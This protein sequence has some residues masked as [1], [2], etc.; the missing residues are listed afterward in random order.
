M[1]LLDVITNGNP[2]LRLRATEVEDVLDPSVQKLITDMIPTMYE[3]DGIGL[4]ANQV[5]SPVRVAVIVPDPTQYRKL[6]GKQDQKNVIVAIN[7]IIISHSVST[8]KGEEGCLSVP[9]IYG[10]V[11]RWKTVTV[12]FQD[13]EGKKVT[14]KASGLLARVFQHE[15]DHLDGILFIDKAENLYELEAPKITI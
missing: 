8:E 1:K 15:I 2:T 7:P 12:S 11:K 5:N 6:K 3:K 10:E 13:R 4:A 14:M 9:G